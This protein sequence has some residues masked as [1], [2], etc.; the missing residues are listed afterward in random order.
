[1]RAP[2]GATAHPNP[3]CPVPCQE[4]LGWQVVSRG[5]REGRA[6]HRPQILLFMNKEEGAFAGQL[7]PLPLLLPVCRYGWTGSQVSVPGAGGACPS[8]IRDYQERRVCLALLWLSRPRGCGKVCRNP[9][10][11][12]Q[13]LLLV[14]GGCPSHTFPHQRLGSLLAG[15]DDSRR[16]VGFLP[17]CPRLQ[18]TSGFVL[19]LCSREQRMV[20]CS[21]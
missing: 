4:R 21:L 5:M 1:M 8:P 15:R 19:G 7:P 12:A 11:A 3:W 14:A 16:G 6:Q 9:V 20:L 17:A 10:P 13:K 2:Q 18:S